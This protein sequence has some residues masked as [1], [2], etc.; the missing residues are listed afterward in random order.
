MIKVLPLL[1]ILPLFLILFLNVE[2]LTVKLDGKLKINSITDG[3]ENKP[4]QNKKNEKIEISNENF[5]D[6]NNKIKLDDSEK[7]LLK[8]N[9]SSFENNLNNV[10]DIKKTENIP[11]IKSKPSKALKENSSRIQFGAFSK[12]K[13]AEIQKLKILGL[14]STKF[15]DFER[16]FAILEENNLFKLIYTAEN[17]SISKLICNYS[18]S[19]KI[20]CLILKR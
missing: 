1:I 8:S 15:P 10:Q 7:V 18:K 14:L 19:V 4:F 5:S 3:N 6:K 9:K 17:L 16:K 20:N 2:N 11:E 12:L 13:N